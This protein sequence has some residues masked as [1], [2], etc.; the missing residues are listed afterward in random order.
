MNEYRRFDNETDDQLIYRISKDKEKIGTW[1]DVSDVLNSLLG[2]SYSESAYRKKFQAFNKMLEANQEIFVNSNSQ[3]EELKELKR[4]LE[5]EKIKVQTEK[6]ELS[7]WMRQ[8]ARDELIYEKIRDCVR[9]QEPLIC[10]EYIEP[11]HNTKAYALVFGDEHYGAEFEIRG[12]YNEIINAYSPEIFEERMWDLFNQVVEFVIKEN[13]DTLHVFSMG[14]FTDGILRMSQ[15]M[16]LRYGVIEGTVRYSNFI[17][18]W[19]NELTKYVRIKYQMT[20]GN[21]SQLRLLDGK[22]GTFEDENMGKIVAEFIKVKLENNPNFTFI[23]NPTGYIYAQLACHTVLGIHGEVK[24]PKK[25]LLEFSK[26]YNVPIDYMIG[27][28][29]HHNYCDELGNN[30]EVIG[31]G[32]IIGADKYSLSLNKTANASAKLLVFEQ[33]KGLVSEHRLKLD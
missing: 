16:K 10:P 25:T 8:D 1:Q 14:D 32:S 33:T 11:V 2:L 18:N 7:R 13:I 30:C 9:E 17:S 26:I 3:L 4:S 22:K 12:L 23:E 31:V 5:K 21:H 27:G 6:L 28:H 15:L 29:L 19:L 20:D 24:D